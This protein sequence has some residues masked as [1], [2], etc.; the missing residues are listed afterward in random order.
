MLFL[1]SYVEPCSNVIAFSLPPISRL[2]VASDP[3][4]NI[5]FAGKFLISLSP[6]RPANE[7]SETCSR[8]LSN[9]KSSVTILLFVVDAR[10]IVVIFSP[11][12]SVV[13]SRVMLCFGKVIYDNNAE[14]SLY[15]LLIPV[16]VV[17]SSEYSKMNGLLYSFQTA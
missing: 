5:A 7:K 14:L 12:I 9:V 11:L 6:P 8:L 3:Y 1:I 17:V 13:P 4:P 15:A 10:L 16:I 2:G